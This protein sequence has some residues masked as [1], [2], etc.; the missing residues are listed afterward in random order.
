MEGKYNWVGHKTHAQLVKLI[1]PHL[2]LFVI[3]LV[4]ETYLLYWNDEL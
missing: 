4:Y 2:A 1:L 3:I